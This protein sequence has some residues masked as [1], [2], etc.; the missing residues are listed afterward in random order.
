MTE[1][2][3]RKY[4][5]GFHLKIIAV[6]TMLIDH[7]GAAV[8]EQLMVSGNAMIISN[9]D[10]IIFWD[11]VLRSIGRAAFPLY[12]FLLVEG[13]IHTSNR[14]KYMIC[15]GIFA[16]VSEIPFD[17]AFFGEVMYWNHQNVFFTLLLGLLTMQG[18][19]CMQKR[20]FI[21]GLLPAIA[22]IMLA[23]VI[24][25]DY[26]GSGILLIIIFYYF[27]ENR[28]N[29]CVWGMLCVMFVLEEIWAL[30]AFFLL[31]LYNGER[32]QKL[33]KYIF[34]AF[35]PLHLCFLFALR[36]VLLAML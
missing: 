34:Y 11:R 6:V 13:F 22:G 5:T 30:P 31:F 29:Q 15:M 10:T 26:G 4:L 24:A 25:G 35:Y 2:A 21:W 33:N 14:K 23:G 27:R 18:I 19:E 20:S 7:V 8:L 16:L 9:Y 32:G 3:S 1:I 28:L 17:M 36:Y 12:C